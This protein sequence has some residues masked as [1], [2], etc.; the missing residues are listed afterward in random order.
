MTPAMRDA[1]REI[2]AASRMTIGPMGIGSHDLSRARGG[3]S[4]MTEAQERW[5]KKLQARYKA[6]RAACPA[7]YRNIVID[8][9]I[10]GTPMTEVCRKRK[11]VR[12]TAVRRFQRGLLKYCE[13][14]GMSTE[15]RNF[16][17]NKGPSAKSS[18]PP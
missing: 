7:I 3:P 4:E 2:E 14:N 15:P 17:L 18:D 12:Q 8:I 13:M 10:D 5:T 16:K 1:E 9:A 11:I 6:W